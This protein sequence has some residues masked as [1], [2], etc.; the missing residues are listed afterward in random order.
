MG[1][2]IYDYYSILSIQFGVFC[3]S[4]TDTLHYGLA[5]CWNKLTL[6][7]TD[8]KLQLYLNQTLLSVLDVNTTRTESKYMMLYDDYTDKHSTSSSPSFEAKGKQLQWQGSR[9]NGH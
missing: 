6:D 7:I 5:G 3:F 2:R 8:D 9:H 1:N 4:N